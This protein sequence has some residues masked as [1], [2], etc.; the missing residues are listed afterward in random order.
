[1]RAFRLEIVVALLVVAAMAVSYLFNDQMPVFIL[2]VV[3]LPA[4]LFLLSRDPG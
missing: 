4:A 1:M 2:T 3:G